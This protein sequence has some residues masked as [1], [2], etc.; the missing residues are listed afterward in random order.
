MEIAALARFTVDRNIT[1]MVFDNAVNYG[2]A[3]AGSLTQGLGCKI[4]FK[5]PGQS[6][7]VH[8]GSGVADFEHDI[9]AGPEID[10]F[11]KII[12]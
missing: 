11:D 10:V 7:L 2:Q 3:H 4:G 6:F 1:A 5:Y 12:G 9:G 8:A